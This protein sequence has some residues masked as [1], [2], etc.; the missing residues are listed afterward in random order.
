MS[1]S[2]LK[3]RISKLKKR[4]LEMI[5]T[6]LRKK[7]MENKY[8]ICNNDVTIASGLTYITEI[9]ESRKT[10]MGRM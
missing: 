2:T 10:K 1:L 6:E 8:R 4:L 3:E 5:Q 9:S 7:K